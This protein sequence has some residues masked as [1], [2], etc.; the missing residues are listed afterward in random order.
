MVRVGSSGIGVCLG[1][2]LLLTATNVLLSDAAPPAHNKEFPYHGATLCNCHPSL[3]GSVSYG[4]LVGIR[5]TTN[6]IVRC[7]HQWCPAALTFFEP[8][9]LFPNHVYTD[10]LVPALTLG[11]CVVTCLAVFLLVTARRREWPVWPGL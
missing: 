3:P 9:H 7:R 11:K 5:Q 8:E 4:L 1:I 10:D 6:R 2:G